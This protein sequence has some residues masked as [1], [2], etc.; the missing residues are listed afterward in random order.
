MGRR[1][2][3]LLQRLSSFPVLRHGVFQNIEESV[4]RKTE[5]LPWLCQRDM[6]VAGLPKKAA[7]KSE[8]SS[9]CISTHAGFIPRMGV[10]PHFFVESKMPNWCE[11]RLSVSGP[12][13]V[14]AEIVQA[15]G[16]DRGEFDFNGIVPM[17]AELHI[18]SDS[19]T[20]WGEMCSSAI[21]IVLLKFR[22]FAF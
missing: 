14:I 3:L 2:S 4:L 8:W 20:S 18:T 19:S 10:T 9:I 22:L 5:L 15:V 1:G 7:I 17:P 12:K 21:G 11:N 13:S 6:K 16:L